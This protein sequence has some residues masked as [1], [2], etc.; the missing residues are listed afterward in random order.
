[1]GFGGRTFAEFAN[2]VLGRVDFAA[3]ADDLSLVFGDEG[4]WTWSVIDLAHPGLYFKCRSR[5]YPI[6]R[7]NQRIRND[8]VLADDVEDGLTFGK[9]EQSCCQRSRRPGG[10]CHDCHLRDVGEEEH[11]CWAVQMG[12]LAV[13]SW[14]V[15]LVT[16]LATIFVLCC[17][18]LGWPGENGCKQS[19]P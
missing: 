17:V 12:M 16:W 3:G 2:G 10:E 5:A 11:E 6:K 13:V 7:I 4:L 15:T 14:I 1:V 18:V 9:Y 8:K 19:Y